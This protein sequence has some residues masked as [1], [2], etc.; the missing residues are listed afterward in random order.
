[1][2]RPS[3][4]NRARRL[5]HSPT[6]AP[7]LGQY[8]MFTG[9][10]TEPAISTRAVPPYRAWKGNFM[11]IKLVDEQ[12]IAQAGQGAP[13][14]IERAYQANP[15]VVPPIALS[16]PHPDVVKALQALAIRL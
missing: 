16:E 15:P 2:N 10:W 7:P 12:T 4:P 8:A 9:F 14:T 1:M 3:P 13:T 5:P 11:A 6:S